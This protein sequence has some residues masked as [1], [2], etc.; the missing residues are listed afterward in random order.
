MFLVELGNIDAKSAIS[1][2]IFWRQRIVSQKNPYQHAPKSVFWGM[3]VGGHPSRPFWGSRV[4]IWAGLG[5]TGSILLEQ[6]HAGSLPILLL[7]FDVACNC[8]SST[9][10]VFT[11]ARQHP[12]L[13]CFSQVGKPW[14]FPRNGWITFVIRHSILQG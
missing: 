5:H 14:T 11:A 3:L 13:L 6:G 2:G 12:V 1:W 8:L 10:R 7:K 9:A 4:K